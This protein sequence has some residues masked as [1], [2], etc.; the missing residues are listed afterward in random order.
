MPM[1]ILRAV[2]LGLVII[3]LQLLV[4][5]IFSSVENTIVSTFNTAQVIMSVSENAV[6]NVTFPRLP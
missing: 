4:P 2:G 3:I 6:K 5:R 1:R